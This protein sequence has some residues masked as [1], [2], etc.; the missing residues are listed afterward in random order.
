MHTKRILIFTLLLS[1]MLF[2]SACVPETPTEPIEEPS[3]PVETEDP[4]PYPESGEEMVRPTD[5]TEPYPDP[6]S[7]TEP[8]AVIDP[9]PGLD[10]SAL[11]EDPENLLDLDAVS[12][13]LNDKNFNRG[14]AFIDSTDIILE[15]SYPVQVKLALTGNLPTPCHQLRVVFSEVD[16]QGNVE[17]EVYSVSD[18]EMMCIQVLEPF[19]ASVPLGEYTQGKYTISINGEPAAEFDLP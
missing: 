18:P 1:G 5:P 15:E 10:D 11:I 3:A 17:I 9:Y 13:V 8:A 16:E 19:E 12:P 4:N 2:L 7:E 6:D 14:A